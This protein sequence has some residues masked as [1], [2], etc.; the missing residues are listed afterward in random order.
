MRKAFIV[1][2]CFFAL[3]LAGVLN[4]VSFATEEQP[5]V[6]ALSIETQRGE[7][8]VIIGKVG[9]L[10]C[11]DFVLDNPSRLIVDFVGATH[12]L[13]AREFT[14]DGTLIEKV[15]TSQFANDPTKITRV[16]FDLKRQAAHTITQEPDR[17]I[18]DFT[19]EGAAAAAQP[20]MMGASM[21]PAMAMPVTNAAGTD[22]GAKNL[23]QF[24]RQNPIARN[25]RN[26]VPD[27]Q[28][29]PQAT[30]PAR[31]N[32]NDRTETEQPATTPPVELAAAW[33]KPRPSAAVAPAYMQDN[34]MQGGSMATA[35]NKNITMDVQNADITTVLQSFSEFAGVNIIAGPEVTG[36]VEA[37]LKD[38]PWK[39]ALQIVLKS[40]GFGYEE[41]YGVI[42]VSTIDKLTKEDLEK[43][44]AE[45]KKDELL[46]LKTEIIQLAY[47]NAD[48][49]QKALK[50]MVSQRGNIEIEKGANALIVTDIQKNVDSIA[51]LA[52]S[53]DRKINQVEIVAKLVDVDV[54]ATTELGIRW[55]FLNL[56]PKNGGVVGDAV[57]DA[58]VPAPVGK[59]RVGTVRSWGE[60]RTVIDM[61]EQSNKANI[62][63]NPRIV[64]ADNREASILV[65]KEIPLIVADEAGN[66]ITELTKVGIGLRVTPHI[67]LDNTITL[68]LH[69]E[70]SEL[71]AQATVQGG[72][73]ISL[74][75][76]DTRVMVKDGETA[77]IGGLMSE[78]ESTLEQ[79]LPV[80]KD[81]PIL[82]GLF[83]YK[84]KSSDKRELI[85][86]ITPRVVEN[87]AAQ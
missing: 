60:L 77:V 67:N 55:D 56:A 79:G 52:K 71:S 31:A 7:T 69:P 38:V 24:S 64:T 53:L 39:Q 57:V 32:A 45:R 59:F 48:E 23:Q 20:P 1:K 28:A 27:R 61:L 26:A 33:Q 66:P 4:L 74:S 40:H 86:F 49:M 54:S 62:I 76:A 6:N 42:R 37:H 2:G 65:G 44:A 68:D 30:P 34:E 51:S 46:P 19:D 82:G 80:L 87:L 14:G 5:A 11:K 35:M 58:G 36:D 83:K 78:V 41:E 3:L 22:A 25:D 43:Q 63:S 75:E 18:I 47:A 15:R 8:K 13:P 72:V 81:V 84:N 16:V 50:K 21:A 70:V 85:I 10:E 73:I 29:A 9:A 12:E 17:I